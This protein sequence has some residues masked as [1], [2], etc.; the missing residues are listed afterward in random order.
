MSPTTPTCPHCRAGL[1]T[2]LPS[3]DGV[4]C[5]EC[6]AALTDTPPASAI[7]TLAPTRQMTGFRPPSGDAATSLAPGDDESPTRPPGAWFLAPPQA[8]DEIGRLGPYRVLGRLGAGGMGAV[9]RA[10]DPSLRRI[11]ALKVMRPDVAADPTAKARF[12]KEARATAAVEHDH[13]VHIFQVSEENGIP[14]LTMPLLRGESLSARLKAAGGPLPVFEAVRI[15]RETAE[16]LAAAHEKGLI[17]RDVKPSN[18]WLEGS[19]R[20]VKILDFGLVRETAAADAGD[21]TLTKVGAMIGTPAYMSPEQARND[22]VDGRSDLFSLGVLL[23]QMVTGRLP[24]RTGSTMAILTSVAID[25]PSPAVLIN[26]LV[27]TA[28]NDLIVELLNKRPEDRP[29]S[30]AVVARRLADIEVTLTA[31]PLA[32]S[33]D[34]SGT[35]AGT[36][37]TVF[38]DLHPEEPAHPTMLADRPRWRPRLWQVA[39]AAGVVIASALGVVQV[40]TVMSAKGTLVIERDAA[41]TDVEVVVKKGG[42]VIRDRTREREI[43]LKTGDYTIEPAEKRGGLRLSTDKVTI[44]R[45]GRPVVRVWVEKPKEPVKKEPPVSPDRRAADWLLAKSGVQIRVAQGEKETQVTRPAELPAGDFAIVAVGVP[46]QAFFV[47]SDARKLEPLPRLTQLWLAGDRFDDDVVRTLGRLKGLT[48]LVLDTTPVTDA[49][50]A[51]LVELKKLTALGLSRSKVT[52]AGLKHLAR[53][54]E[55]HILH[56]DG[57]AVTDAG[58]ERLAEFPALDGLVVAKTKVTAAGVKKLAAAKPKCRIEW[59]GGTLGPPVPKKD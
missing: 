20:R 59:D 1:P 53:L 42:A 47:E 16:G 5:P 56:L 41:A 23:Y 18:V 24:F 3:A 10:E 4:H 29:G 43:E 14:Y 27:P 26:P 7:D 11:I 36:P 40:I 2:D 31:V 50:V 19:R 9:F 17:H 51:G 22:A 49:G 13:I 21:S 58:L 54:P 45:N 52:D 57:T 8:P 46:P 48:V 25:T 33:A 38:A 15:A 39:V 30:A 28:L 32:G 34:D 44:E 12:L 37:D 55:L 6:G 35:D